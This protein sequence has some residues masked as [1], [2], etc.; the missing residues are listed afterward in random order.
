M[1]KKKSSKKNKA[2]IFTMKSGGK[3]KIILEAVDEVKK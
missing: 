2:M 3:N 1:N